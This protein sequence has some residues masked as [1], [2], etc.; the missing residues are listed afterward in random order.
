MKKK[1]L[2]DKSG[3]VRELTPEDMK[4][5]HS[6]SETLPADLAAKLPKKRH[7]QR[8]PQKAPTKDQVTLRLDHD[9]VEHFKAAGNGWQSRIN[10]ALRKAIKKTG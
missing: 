4:Q 10:A 9:V 1:P 2:T 5:F 3:N 7:G 6:A 8:G